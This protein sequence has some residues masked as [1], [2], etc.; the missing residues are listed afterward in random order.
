M[1]GKDGLEGGGRLH[2]GECVWVKGMRNIKKRPGEDLP[3][4]V[5]MGEHENFLGIPSTAFTR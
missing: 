3:R 4:H 5:G 1:H 2:T